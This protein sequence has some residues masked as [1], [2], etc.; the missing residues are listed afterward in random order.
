MTIQPSRGSSLPV[1]NTSYTGGSVMFLPPLDESGERP[2]LGRGTGVCTSGGEGGGAYL[3]RRKVWGKQGEERS[4]DGM[5]RYILLLNNSTRPG[6]QLPPR[7][8]CFLPK[9]YNERTAPT[10]R[11]AVGRIGETESM[12]A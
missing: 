4:A 3:K 10:Q 11:V 2:E 9:D 7:Q 8:G 1:K 12:M 5:I 6:L